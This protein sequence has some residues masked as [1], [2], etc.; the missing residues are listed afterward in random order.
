VSRPDSPSWPRVL[1]LLAR[2]IVRTMPWAT[3]VTGC[4]AGVILLAVLARVADT[5]RWSLDQGAVRLT[6]LPAIAGLAF[7][8]RDELRPLTQAAPVPAWLPVAGHLLLAVPVL[9]ATCWVQ[10]RITDHTVAAAALRHA[11][12]LCPL[13]AELAGWSAVTVAVAA[14]VGRSRYADLGGAVAVPV[15]FAAIALA[16]YLPVSARHLTQPPAAAHAVMVTWYAIAAATLTVAGLALRDQ[17]LRYSRRRCLRH[18]GRLSAAPVRGRGVPA[19]AISP[20]SSE[21]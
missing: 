4:L 12:A 17:W 7:V 9:A 2:P 14:C 16:W 19:A 20:D 10:L 8:V 1:P 5:S 13:I 21:S 11:P 6:F 15:S 3:L 18:R